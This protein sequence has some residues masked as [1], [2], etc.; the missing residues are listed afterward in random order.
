MCQTCVG[1]DVSDEDVSSCNAD[2]GDEEETKEDE[3]VYE[4]AETSKDGAGTKQTRFQQNTSET[5]APTSKHPHPR[6]SEKEQTQKGKKDKK[7]DKQITDQKSTLDNFITVSTPS[8]KSSN[9]AP[10]LR[11]PPT[12]AEELESG[13]KAKKKQRDKSV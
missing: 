1:E 3:E 10:D 9:L 5:P 12:P 2:S 13:S 11:S 8:R 6:T 7:K 4:E